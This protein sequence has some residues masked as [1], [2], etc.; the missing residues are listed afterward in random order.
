[1]TR[2]E[3]TRGAGRRGQVLQV[4]R[5]AA[6]PLGIAEIADRLGVHVNTVRFHLDTL[7]DNGQVEGTR[8]EST[9][10]GRPPQLYRAV[11]TM[12]PTGPRHYRALAE[13]LA[14]T[15]ATEPAPQER[16]IEAGRT[17]GRRESLHV[18]QYIEQKDGSDEEQSVAR[19]VRLL[20]DLDFAPESAADHIGLRHCPFLELAADHAEVVCQVH[21]GLMQGAMESWESAITV[22]RL[23]AFV[24]PDLCV[25]H[26]SSTRP[27]V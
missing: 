2:S 15:L 20:A 6:E 3:R 10:P 8:A 26:L 12:D 1:M 19:L 27:S 13:A 23:D 5:D 11:R 7:V 21:L 22:D 17:W 25:A 14:A 4:L 24:E 18:E 16:A 9:G